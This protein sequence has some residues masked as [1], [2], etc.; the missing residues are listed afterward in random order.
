[1]LPGSH[2]GE[3]RVLFVGRLVGYKGLPVLFEA[4]RSLART[5]PT[6]RLYVA[7]KG[8]MEAELRA[9]ARGPELARLIE[10]LGFVPD[11]ALGELYRSV[12]VVACPS[13]N[14]LESTPTALEEAAACGTRTLGTDL[15]G[16]AE[17]L[18]N[19]GEHGMLVPP[20]DVAA[21]AAALARLLDRGPPGSRLPIRTW[22]DTAGDYLALFAEL[23]ADVPARR[24]RPRFA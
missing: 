17:N 5:R 8:P 13:L 15:P 20:N 23:G 10:F 6:L 11:A 18:P 4:V 16:T 2:P 24:P 3:E 14:L 1:M 12:D 9:R 21:T 22:D 7:G 19:D